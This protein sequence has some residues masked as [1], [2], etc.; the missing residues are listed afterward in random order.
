MIFSRLKIGSGF[1]GLG[2]A[3]LT[4][5]DFKIELEFEI[6]SN[7]LELSMLLLNG[8]EFDAIIDWGDG[9][10]EYIN[11][12]GS[13]NSIGHTY[14][15]FGIKRVSIRGKWEAL[16]F[17]YNDNKIRKV[18]S[19]GY[20]NVSKLKYINF[21]ES[22]LNELPPN[23][24][25]SSFKYI[26]DA[27]ESFGYYDK[28]FASTKITS[29]PADL[30][31][32]CTLLTDIKQCFQD[33]SELIS[34]D[35][36]AFKGLSNITNMFAIF[37]SSGILTIPQD[38]FKYYNNLENVDSMFNNCRNLTTISSTLFSNNTNINNFHQIFRFCDNLN[39]D[40]PEF[41]NSIF[42]PN[43]SNHEECFTECEPGG[44]SNITNWS[45][46]PSDW[47]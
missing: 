41:W 6:P 40:V 9:S 23:N 29:I 30:F 20:P 17:G 46:I 8:Y 36:T 10:S 35:S 3:F 25:N 18:I 14:I 2:G 38:L 33:C 1:V 37:S 43:V 27:S 15:I 22:A 7:D 21:T 26:D 47:I 16:K 28:G 19:F 42:W 12:I 4:K 31:K 44:I 32:G 45:S 39:G 5:D 24:P 13:N 34:V 11:Q